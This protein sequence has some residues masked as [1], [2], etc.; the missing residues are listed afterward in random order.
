MNG[1]RYKHIHKSK[2]KHMHL[3]TVALNKIGSLVRLKGKLI[4]QNAGKKIAMSALQQLWSRS[5]R[6]HQL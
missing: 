4:K 3:V 5:C 6:C 1:A 2:S